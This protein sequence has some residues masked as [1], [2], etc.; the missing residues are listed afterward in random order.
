MPIPIKYLCYAAIAELFTYLPKS[1]ANPQDVG[2]RQR[3]Q[4]ASWMSLWPIKNEKHACVVLHR[5]ALR[6]ECW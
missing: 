3:L 1:K 4:V 5:T 6:L 2:V